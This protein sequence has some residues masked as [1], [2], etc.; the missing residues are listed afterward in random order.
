VRYDYTH[1]YGLH[2][3]MV[4]QRLDKNI[5][6]GEVIQMYCGLYDADRSRVQGAYSVLND[7]GVLVM[8]ERMRFNLISER[9]KKISVDS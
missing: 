4:R 6:L 5:N 9:M 8:N 7:W 2:D 1:V 3:F